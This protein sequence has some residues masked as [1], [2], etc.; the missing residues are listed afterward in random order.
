MVTARRAGFLAADGCAVPRDLLARLASLPGDRL[1]ALL[2]SAAISFL[3]RRDRP[4]PL[5]AYFPQPRAPQPPFDG[6]FEPA[7]GARRQK[8]RR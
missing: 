5:A 2:A 1:P 6:G 7:A 4:Q 8:R 3:I